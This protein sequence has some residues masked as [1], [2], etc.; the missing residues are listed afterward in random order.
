[1]NRTTYPTFNENSDLDVSAIM[2][3]FC[4]VVGTVCFLSIWE[5]RN[6]LYF[7]FLVM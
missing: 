1:M 2:L 6:L 5:K 7:H 4:V 3:L